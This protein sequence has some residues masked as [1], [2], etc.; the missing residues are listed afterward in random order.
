LASSPS[1]SDRAALLEAIRQALAG[2]PAPRPAARTSLQPALHKLSILLVEDNAVN[3]KLGI[4][5]LEKMGHTVTLAL[6]GQI[7]VDIVRSQRFD[8]ILMDIQ[9]PVLSGLDA[10]RAIR[11][12]EQGRPHTPIIG[13]DRARYGW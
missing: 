10:T 4:R 5:M 7:A 12:W 8:L 3:Q 6:N 1:P 2:T 9:M 11:A 13:H